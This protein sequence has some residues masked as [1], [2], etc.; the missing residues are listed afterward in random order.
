MSQSLASRFVSGARSQRTR[1]QRTTGAVLTARCFAWERQFRVRSSDAGASQRLAFEVTGWRVCASAQ[2]HCAGRVTARPALGR[3][4]RPQSVCSPLLSP[5]AAPGAVTA[6][7]STRSRIACGAAR[8]LRRESVAVPGPQRRGVAF[9][10]R[11][12][13]S[14]KG[15]DAGRAR[16]LW[17][18][19]CAADPSRR[20]PRPL[21]TAPTAAPK[22]G[23]KGKVTGPRNPA[24]G[25]ETL[26]SE[27]RAEAT[28]RP[29]SGPLDCLRFLV[30]PLGAPCPPKA[31][32][33]LSLCP[34]LFRAA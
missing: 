1:S 25:R 29:A 18:Q 6:I 12:R 10:N 24:E 11:T 22:K 31:P 3:A 7:G 17:S 26:S 13:F 21:G 33:C 30:S 34:P 8:A 2:R 19:V 4:I 23:E 28:L 27:E 9:I 32:L 15:A 5:C 20:R 14:V 16:P